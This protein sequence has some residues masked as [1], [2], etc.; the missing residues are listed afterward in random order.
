MIQV[1]VD[2]LKANVPELG[3]RVEGALELVKLVQDGRYPH[4]KGAMVVPAGLR[5]G[6]AEVSTGM[7]QQNYAEAI[8]VIVVARATD[9]AGEKALKDLQPLIMQIVE[10]IAGWA[11]DET[12]GV[13]ELVDGRLASFVNS[14]VIYQVNFSINNELRISG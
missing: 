12:V 4:S 3:D 7:F 9:R 6:V 10:T 5:G 11:P 8:S 2:R 13:F 1:V 14:Q